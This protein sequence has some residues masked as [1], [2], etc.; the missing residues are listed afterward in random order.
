MKLDR[1]FP[2]VNIEKLLSKHPYYSKSFIPIELY[3]RADNKKDVETVGV[4]AI[5]LTSAKIPDD[6]VYATTKAIFDGFDSLGE[7]DPVLST[8][9]KESMLESLTAPIHS[10]A[11]RYYKEMGLKLPPS[12]L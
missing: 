12:A 5:F 8:F 1:L 7:Y 3:P 6:V 10:G 9:S 2:L 11:L 4:K